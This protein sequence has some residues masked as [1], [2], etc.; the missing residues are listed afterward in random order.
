M[1]K[2]RKKE[3]EK[4]G[5]GKRRKGKRRKGEKEEGEKEEGKRGFRTMKVDWFDRYIEACRLQAA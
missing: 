3:G 1:G 4:G 2:G 5:R